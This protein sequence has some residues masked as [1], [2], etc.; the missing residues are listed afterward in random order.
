MVFLLFL[1]STLT[2]WSWTLDA[3][4]FDEALTL[5]SWYRTALRRQNSLDLYVESSKRAPC[6]VNRGRSETCPCHHV[7]IV[8]NCTL[9]LNVMIVRLL[10][11]SGALVGSNDHWC[12]AIGELVREMAVG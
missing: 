3:L 9:W 4:V 10:F 2:F 1:R 12:V 8:A 5:F 7:H 11:A 6:R